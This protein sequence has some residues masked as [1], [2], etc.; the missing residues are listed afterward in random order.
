MNTV[1]S[2]AVIIAAA[3]VIL[4]HHLSSSIQVYETEPVLQAFKLLRKKGIG[5]IPIV[6]ASG[7]KPVGN[8]SLRDIY[9]LLMA[10]EIY[11][12]YR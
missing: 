12:D 8:I 11:H 9:F 5:G 7:R 2:K 6:D 3:D 1:T 4:P 10:P